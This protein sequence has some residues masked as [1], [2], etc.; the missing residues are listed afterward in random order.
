MQK[1]TQEEKR[2]RRNERAKRNAAERA[3]ATERLKALNIDPLLNEYEH[4]A[5]R[6]VTVSKIRDERLN[7]TGPAFIKDGYNVRWR[8][9][10]IDAW[11]DKREVTST[12][13]SIGA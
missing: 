6:G 4:A 11:L 12:T 1:L 9:S 10:T 8:R 13:A 3:K 7:G 5:Y 2:A